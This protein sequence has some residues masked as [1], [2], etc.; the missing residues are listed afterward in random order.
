MKR[1][2]EIVNGCRIGI[3]YEREGDTIDTSKFNL[4]SWGNE[5][6]IPNFPYLALSVTSLPSMLSPNFD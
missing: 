5:V 2:L 3:L 6:F 1:L 4:V